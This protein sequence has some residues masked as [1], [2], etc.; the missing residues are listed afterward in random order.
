MH[1]GEVVG[2][3]AGRLARRVQW[4]AQERKTVNAGQR[5]GRLRLR[6]HPSAE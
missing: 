4:K 6:R 5:C 2:P 3:I 1:L